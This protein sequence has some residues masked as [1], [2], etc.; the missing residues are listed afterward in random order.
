VRRERARIK[1]RGIEGVAERPGAP[2]AAAAATSERV[3]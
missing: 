3:R 1:I 2:A